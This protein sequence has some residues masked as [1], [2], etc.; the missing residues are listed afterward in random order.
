MHLFIKQLQELV[1]FLQSL[2]NKNK[3]NVIKANAVCFIY[4]ICTG[5]LD[6]AIITTAATIVGIAVAEAI[7]ITAV[8]GNNNNP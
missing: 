8:H 3:I 2:S 4:K 6:A 5:G 7:A 1:F